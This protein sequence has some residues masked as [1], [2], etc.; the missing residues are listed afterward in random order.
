[1]LH[2]SPDE[3]YNPASLG[4]ITKLPPD[5][6]LAFGLMLSERF[7]PN[8]F[9]FFLVEQWGNPMALLNGVTWIQNTI[10]RQS[11]DEE[12]RQHL[13]DL[14]EGVTPDMEQF[15]GNILASLAIDVSSMLH[16]CFEFVADRRPERMAQCAEIALDSL[17][18]YIQ[19]RDHLPH[20][21]PAV[22]LDQ[23]LNQDVLIQQE[24]S[25]QLQLLDDLALL[26]PLGPSL[27]LHKTLD[28]PNLVLGHLPDVRGQVAIS[29]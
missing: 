6:Q 9:A 26:P 1:M 2:K 4:K 14:I 10:A 27:Y 5:H 25:Y 16:E 18:M 17:R 15:P 8:Y 24:L 28:A 20:D 11:F 7:L 21:L 23:Q 29:G 19:K 3:N 13:D 12:E 22:A